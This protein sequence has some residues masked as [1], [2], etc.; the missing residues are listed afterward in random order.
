M[1]KQEA[2]TLLT[3]Q[4]VGDR[5]VAA[6]YL[7][8][9]ATPQEMGKLK[10]QLS[11]ESDVWVREIITSAV[12]GPRE[13][14]NTQE[15]PAPLSLPE[16]AVEEEVWAKALADTAEKFLHELAP[17][18]SEIERR[19]ERD[20]PG[21]QSSQTEAGIVRLKRYLEGMRRLRT[22]AGFPEITDLDLTDLVVNLINLRQ[23]HQKGV[24][25]ILTREEPLYVRGD[26]TFLEFAIDNGLKNAIEA[27]A[28]GQAV[29]VNLGITDKDAWIT[30]LDEGEGLPSGAD[31]V[32]ETGK[33]TKS[34]SEHAGMGL[35]IAQQ[36]MLSM[37]G[38]AEVRPRRDGGVE[39][40]LR[41]PQGNVG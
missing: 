41:W 34:K 16:V 35:P 10:R 28:P 1:D 13:Q 11:N 27:S 6:R 3:S 9:N 4:K 32:W 7:A 33:T 22:V 37:G 21:Y 30:I 15:T 14:R 18:V 12:G 39:F 17:L 19:A 29:L 31:K 24:E 8:S 25:V 26:Q 38:S 2:L 36:A 40:E 20:V 23:A 5:R